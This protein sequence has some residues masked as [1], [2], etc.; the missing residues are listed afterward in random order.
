MLICP[1]LL[2]NTKINSSS[3]IKLVSSGSIPSLDKTNGNMYKESIS[4]HLLSSTNSALYLLEEKDSPNYHILANKLLEA[5]L[6]YT[7]AVHLTNTIISSLTIF[8]AIA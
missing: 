8:L 3:A 4:I 1:L 5:T 2:L 7:V 6:N